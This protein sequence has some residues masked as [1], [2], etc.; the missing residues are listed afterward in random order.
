MR[1]LGGNL[2]SM[3][4]LG[5]NLFSMGHLGRNFFR[6]QWGWANVGLKLGRWAIVE[7]TSFAVWV[8]CQTNQNTFFPTTTI[9]TT[10]IITRGSYFMTVIRHLPAHDLMQND[11]ETIDVASSKG[12]SCLRNTLRGAPQAVCKKRTS[13]YLPFHEITSRWH[14]RILTDHGRSDCY[15]ARQ[16][17]A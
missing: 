17:S 13:L 12:R 8:Q 5:G 14:C 1:H 16:A 15:C 2:L 10:A 4:H 9:T 6:Q 7:Q 3:G 11:G